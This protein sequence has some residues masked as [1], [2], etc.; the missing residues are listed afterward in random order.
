MTAANIARLVLVAAIGGGAF[1]LMR[2]TV[3]VLGPAVLAEARLVI[4]AVFLMLVSLRLRKPLDART[5]WRYYAGLGVF[6]F[7]LPILLIGYAAESLP[8]S[9]MA[10]LNAT[11]PMFAAA[12][13]ALQSRQRLPKQRM[14]GLMLGLVGVGVIVGLDAAPVDPWA[15][16]AVLGAALSYAVATVWAGAAKRVDPVASTHGGLWAAALLL[17]PAALLAPDAGVALWQLPNE[18]AWQVAAGVLA[19]GVL[20]SGLAFLLYFSLVSDLGPTSALTVTFL[21]PMFGVLWGHLIL[22][23]AVGLQVLVGGA[24]VVTGT[25]LSIGSRREPSRLQVIKPALPRRSDATARP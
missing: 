12:L 13:G 22:G 1:M 15:A 5:H 17:A 9:L 20:C 23:E 21:V 25:M 7:A 10:I 4:A 11:S 24:I 16:L 19:L 18:L 3:P 14:A 8:A 6:S 2:M